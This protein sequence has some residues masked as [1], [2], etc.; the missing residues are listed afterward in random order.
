MGSDGKEVNT[1]SCTTKI[2]TRCLDLDG[3]RDSAQHCTLRS[4][5][6]HGGPAVMNHATK[7]LGHLTGS[8]GKA[9]DSRFW[10]Q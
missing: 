10:K 7:G 4:A 5:H 9:P 8:G 1:S 2:Q 6:P 3:R